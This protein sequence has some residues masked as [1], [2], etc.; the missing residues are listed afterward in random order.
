M[1][2]IVILI[3]Y[4]LSIWGIL[5]F[6]ATLL[7]G[8]LACCIGLPKEHFYISLIVFAIIGVTL[9]SIC[10]ARGCKKADW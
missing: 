3:C 9:T 7:F 1:K 2:K 5:G 4:H 10:V 6:F 8:F